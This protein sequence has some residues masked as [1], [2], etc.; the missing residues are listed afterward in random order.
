MSKNNF[1]ETLHR[2]L[3]SRRSTERKLAAYLL[4]EPE[5]SA[6]MSAEELAEASGVSTASVSRMLRSA[7]ML[8]LRGA[9]A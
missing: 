7:G 4:S 8:W 1:P 2:M 3:S 9:A 5:K 6:V